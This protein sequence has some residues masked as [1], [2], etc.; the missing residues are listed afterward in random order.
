MLSKLK[1]L[2][3][4]KSKK[5]D[6][7]ALQL[8]KMVYMDFNYRDHYRSILRREPA[9]KQIAELFLFR[10]WAV[11]YGYSMLCKE[12]ATADEIIFQCV[13]MYQTFGQLF[14]NDRN[15]MN[16]ENELCDDIMSLIDNRWRDYDA[17]AFQYREEMR[18]VWHEI[19]EQCITA[20]LLGIPNI[21][22]GNNSMDIIKNV[23]TASALGVV[24]HLC[25]RYLSITDQS[26]S[27]DLSNDF[28]NQLKTIARLSMANGL[29]NQNLRH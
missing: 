21:F 25:V 23:K 13:M 7:I 28:I 15:N 19:L 16:I 24:N 20:D 1:S 5:P 9:P 8:D 22:G 18:K 6:V 29:G 26:I 12:K 27:V 2:F 11:Q 10:A 14:I 3:T 17:I 4:G